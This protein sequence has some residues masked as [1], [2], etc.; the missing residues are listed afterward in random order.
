MALKVV[1]IVQARMG[2]LRLPNKMMLHLHGYPIVEW[3]YRRVKQSKLIDQIIF[4]LPNTE[5]DDVLELYLESIGACVCRG[6][7]K[8][9]VDRFYKTAKSVSSD[10]VVRVCAD[11]Q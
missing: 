4:A 1:A 3:I 6:S 9:L 10:Q 2:A 5:Q 11:N 8:N 7:E